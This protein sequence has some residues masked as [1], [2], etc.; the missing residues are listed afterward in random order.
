MSKTS[1]VVIPAP[2]LGNIYSN[3][4]LMVVAKLLKKN[5]RVT[6]DMRTRGSADAW[7]TRSGDVD[8]E[9]AGYD[10][11]DGYA[12]ITFDGSTDDDETVAFPQDGKG[13]ADDLEYGRIEVVRK[14]SQRTRPSQAQVAKNAALSQSRPDDVI[15][16]KDDSEYVSL[17]YAGTRLTRADCKKVAL[18]PSEW[19]KALNTG[20]RVRDALNLQLMSLFITERYRSLGHPGDERAKV[21]TQISSIVSQLEAVDEDVRNGR[22][23]LRTNYA[24]RRGVETDLVDLEGAYK[25]AKGLRPEIVSEM[26]R[27]HQE[28][29]DPDWITSLRDKAIVTLKATNAVPQSGVYVRFATTREDRRAQGSN[30]RGTTGARG[31]G[32][33]AT[34]RGR[35]GTTLETV[36]D[37]KLSEL[38]KEE[39]K[40]LKLPAD[41]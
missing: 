7:T 26:K 33:T 14:A 37:K 16:D 22:S 35:F 21:Q 19:F 1:K 36:K 24:W 34:G 27:Q 28:D 5:D 25:Q 3:A 18:S 4:E 32:N 13:Q 9:A 40:A 6:L 12:Y 29:D 31:R 30:A 17:D 2:L 41:F 15:N 11:A 8:W 39:R 38:T 10:K 20:D 23:N